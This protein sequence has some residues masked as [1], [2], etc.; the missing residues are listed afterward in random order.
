MPHDSSSDLQ[1]AFNLME[2]FLLD[3]HRA[4]IQQEL[5]TF[6]KV[7]PLFTTLY[8]PEPATSTRGSGRN[9]KDE[10]NTD[11]RNGGGTG[12]RLGGSN[13]RGNDHQ[14]S[15]S[16]NG[17]SNNT[18][19]DNPNKDKGIFICERMPYFISKH[20]LDGAPHP[21]KVTVDRVKTVI[22]L[23]GSS[24]GRACANEQCRFAHIF[25]LDKI[26]K[27]VSELNT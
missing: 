21:R 20:K 10:A 1:E 17:D 22:C 6:K 4:I 14:N 2:Y 18:N 27:G 15:R 24:R 9:K 12:G 3:L 23:K 5:Y 19:S 26:I 25:K 7:P 16:T 8:P 11:N 13:K